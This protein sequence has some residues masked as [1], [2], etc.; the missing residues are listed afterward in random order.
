MFADA[1][2]IEA[3]LISELDLLEQAA[4]AFSRGD[5]RARDRVRRH[6]REAVEAE[7]ECVSHCV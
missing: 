4:E 7:L 5:R 1:V 6:F 2:D 3:D